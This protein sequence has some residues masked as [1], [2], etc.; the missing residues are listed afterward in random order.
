MDSLTASELI[1]RAGKLESKPTI[2]S[3][4]F[5]TAHLEE[6]A[7]C[8]IKAGNLLRMTRDFF[9]ASECFD[10][11]SKCYKQTGSGSEY[12][13]IE[14]KINVLKCYE[15]IDVNKTRGLMEELIMWFDANGKPLR[16]VV[17]LE[18]LASLAD[19]T[20]Q[21]ITFLIRAKEHYEMEDQ[22]R[23]AMR[24]VLEIATNQMKLNLFKEAIE[25]F[26]MV[27]S[28]YEGDVNKWS[29][30][31]LIYRAM[32]CHLAIGDS[33]GCRN[34]LDKYANTYQ[35]FRN[36]REYILFDEL[37]S[38]IDD[39]DADKMAEIIAKYDDIKPLDSESVHLLLIVK[40]KVAEGSLT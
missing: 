28:M 33:I 20:N 12:D 17:Y 25:N 23:G 6:A 2:Y 1:V 5:G 13:S 19:D 21:K 38:S 24:C 14:Q 31:A 40:N 39:V 36:S 3:K 26:E 7:E 29:I 16:S 8:Y 15:H 37:I 35:M 34:A 22:Q 30:S 4:I 27:I 18:K 9:G 11:A 32:L 10:K